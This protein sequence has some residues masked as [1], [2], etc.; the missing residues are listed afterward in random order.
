MHPRIHELLGYLDNGRADLR[1]AIDS[2]PAS[3][4]TMRPAPEGWSAADVLEHLCLGERRRNVRQT[5]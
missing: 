2:V 4:L 3:H 5:A 1:Q